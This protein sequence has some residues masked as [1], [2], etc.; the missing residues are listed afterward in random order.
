[1]ALIRRFRIYPKIIEEPDFECVRRNR[2]H[3]KSELP[4]YFRIDNQDILAWEAAR[5]LVV[6]IDAITC[7]GSFARDICYI[8]E[9]TFEREYLQVEKSKA[10]IAGL[11]KSLKLRA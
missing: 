3:S 9:E 4:L 6:E 11:K 8:D 1:M 10:L 7:T 2:T 5:K